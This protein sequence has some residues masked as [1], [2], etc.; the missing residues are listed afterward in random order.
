MLPQKGVCIRYLY[1]YFNRRNVTIDSCDKDR[2]APLLL[3]SCDDY[4]KKNRHPQ[5]FRQ[6]SLSLS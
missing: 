1:D 6:T 3:F 4:L 2:T 5:C